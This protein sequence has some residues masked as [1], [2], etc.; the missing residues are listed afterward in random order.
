MINCRA[1]GHPPFTVAVIHGGPG[2]S[3]EMAPV[4]RELSSRRGVLEPLQTA[5]SLEGQVAEL[6]AVLDGQAQIPIALIGWSWGAMLS[7]ILA[8]RHPSLVRKLVLVSSGPYLADYATGIMNTRGSR[9]DEEE[10]AEAHV[11]MEALE[12][13]EGAERDFAFARLGT[14]ISKAD[15]FDPMEHEDDTIECRFDIFM[16]VWKDAEELR[17][18]GRLLEMGR[19]IRCP[20]V[21]IHGDYDPHPPE[22]VNT[23]LSS[24]LSDF[25]FI[26]MEKCGHKPWIERHARERFYGLLA[27]VVKEPEAED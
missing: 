12:A 25:R 14:L 19:D 7:Y 4:A 16:S 24:I 8:S 1:Y 6:K 27:D 13:G 10:R 15:S 20:V 11:L 3:G 22:G 9:L 26:L 23:P 5:S 17:R 2:A 18:S 21:A